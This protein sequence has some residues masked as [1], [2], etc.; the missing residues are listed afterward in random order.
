MFF[1]NA[2]TTVGAQSRV[3][4]NVGKASLD[5]AGRGEHS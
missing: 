2:D 4:L 3:E 1:M 5:E